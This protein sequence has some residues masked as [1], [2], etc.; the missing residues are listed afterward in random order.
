MQGLV[1]RVKKIDLQYTVS[2]TQSEL[3]AD[4]LQVW[5]SCIPASP[6]NC[7]RQHAYSVGW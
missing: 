3:L 6:K 2:V 1:A 7:K 4:S 5:A